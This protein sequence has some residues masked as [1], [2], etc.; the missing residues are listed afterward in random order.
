MLRLHR[1][2]YRYTYRAFC[3][4]IPHVACAHSGKSAYSARYGRQFCQGSI[5]KTARKQNPRRIGLDDR[6]EK[7]GYKV[8]EAR[9]VDRVPYMLI[10]GKNEIENRVVSV[11]SRE[12]DQTETM[13]FDEFL[14]KINDQIKNR[15]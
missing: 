4:Q 3:R 14:A 7:I 12:T 1:A 15:I 5:R 10:I 11:R 6:N 13:T 8:R 9:Q 2:F